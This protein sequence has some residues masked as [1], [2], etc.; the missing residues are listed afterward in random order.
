MFR[1]QA[2]WIFILPLELPAK[3]LRHL[4]KKCRRAAPRAEKSDKPAVAFCKSRSTF[5]V[6]Y[7][8]EFHGA[9]S[10]LKI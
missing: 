1:A 8:N 9:S 7:R 5:T 2:V 3:V 6:S 10:V 4:P